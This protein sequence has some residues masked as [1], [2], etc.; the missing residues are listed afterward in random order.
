MS[1]ATSALQRAS[2]FARSQGECDEDSGAPAAASPPRVSKSAPVPSP[3]GRPAPS[4]PSRS[5]CVAHKPSQS[6]GLGNLRRLGFTKLAECLLSIPKAYCDFTRPVRR[7]RDVA[8]PLGDEVRPSKHYFILKACDLSLFD[9]GGRPTTY[10]KRAFRV[11]IDCRD[12]AGVSVR[13]SVFGNVWPWQKIS[14]GDDVHVYG[15]LSYWNGRACIEYAQLVS[16]S[17][18]GRV[19]P[20]YGGKPGQVSGDTLHKGVSAAMGH[21]D[22]AEVAM[23]AQ[24]GIRE[25]DFLRDVGMTPRQLLLDL[26]APKTVAAGNAARSIARRLSADAVIRRA[27]AARQR[28]AVARSAIAID[29]KLVQELVSE[30]PFA[31]T[32]DQRQAINEVIDDLRSAFPMRRL[33]SG[34]VG[35]GKSITFM[36]PVAAAYAAGAEVAIL[37]PSQ[38]VVEQLAR[39]LRANFPGLPVCEVLAGGAIGEGVSVGTTA[40]LAAARKQKKVYDLVVV[41]EQ[42]KFSVEQK[43]ALLS[44]HTNLIEAT[45]TAIP[46]SLALVNYGGMDV[47]VIRECPVKKEIRTRVV[48][49]SDMHKVHQVIREILERGGQVAVVYPLVDVD[50]TKSTKESPE[51]SK[52]VAA[53]PASARGASIGQSAFGSGSAGSARARR[54]ARDGTLQ[55]VLEAGAEWELLYPGRVGVLHGRMSA[56]EKADVIKAMHENKISIL[57]SSLVIE[58][59]VTLPSLKLMVI[60]SPERYGLSQLH[61]L[62]GRVARKGGR[63][64]MYLV[65]SDVQDEALQR[66]R[67]LERCSDGF[68]LAEHD[69]ELRGFGDVSDDSEAQ[70]GSTR[71]LFFG[72]GLTHADLAEATKRLKISGLGI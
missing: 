41:D 3:A 38:L 11:Q 8:T 2:L 39:E 45:A 37:A 67:L 5:P 13:I 7:I 36:L 20:V 57:V 55:S 59:G 32:G 31:L 24:A 18:R 71:T 44:S 25:S 54:Q 62:R 50:S 61:Q 12:A 34:D 9:Q 33:L 46:R 68:T 40:L 29:R 53:G 30:L 64:F 63:G 52:A 58:V 42:H 35:T 70:T 10:W 22:E 49:K 72:A 19:A 27:A 23:L 51:P 21:L 69:M 66:L 4:L 1:S 14:R 6:D 17:Q 26:H 43:S 56:E 16:G 15:A 60:D 65:A 28:K 48:N 47:S